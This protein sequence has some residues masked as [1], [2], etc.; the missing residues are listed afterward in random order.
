MLKRLICLASIFAILCLSIISVGA[1]S[2]SV[3]FYTDINYT[4][5]PVTLSEGRYNLAQLNVE[6]IRNDDISSIQIPKGYI[7]IV[8]EHENFKGKYWTFKSNTPNMVNYGCNDVMSSVVICKCPVIKDLGTLGES[9]SYAVDI[10]EKGQVVGYSSDSGYTG[11]NQENDGKRAFLWNNG[12]MKDLGKIGGCYSRVVAINENGQVLGNSFFVGDLGMHAIMWE[13]GV[14]KDLGTL[15]GTISQ[16]VAINEK[17]Q[18]V[19]YS[20]T[21]DYEE[22]A[23]IWENGVM[24]D[25]GTL[26]GFSSRALAINGKGQVV[27]ISD[28]AN[29]KSHAFIWENGVMKDMG[30]LGGSWAKAEAIN[31][32]GQV[33]GESLIAGDSQEHAFIWENGVMTDLGTLGGATSTAVDIN[34]KGQ[35]LGNSDTANKKRHVFIWKN[36]LMNDLGTLEEGGNSYAVA[37]NE[38]GQVIGHSGTSNNEYNTFIWENGL[39]KDLGLAYAYDINENGQ[40]VGYLHNGEFR[41]NAVIWEDASSTATATN[42]ATSTATPTPRST[43][44]PISTPT[45]TSITGGV[46]VQMFNGTTTGTTTALTPKLKL[47]NT[48]TTA[49]NLSNVTIRYYYTIDGE[50]TQNFNCDWATAGN[51][52][53]T[54]K[55]VKMT[56]AKTGADYYLEIGFTSSAG[57]LQP[58]ASTEIQTRFIKSDWTNY[59]QTGDYSFNSSATGYVDWNKTTAYINGSLKFGIEP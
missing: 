8:Y 57:T 49:V 2:T 21:S 17:G 4:K 39:M 16:A 7:V 55:F 31:E 26:G 12:V 32:K 13:N 22:H 15:G 29:N 53:I 34:E 54:S 37:I 42:T 23:F 59:T 6:G 50:R 11:N 25:L 27:G 36:G 45:P 3:T 20:E 44:T 47:I 52:N 24:K 51:N 10:N 58:G 43:T 46:K 38:N 40:V 5:N 1:E 48:G 28:T 35:V 33:V 41:T 30:T 19:G 9:Y 56:T 14:L 18:V